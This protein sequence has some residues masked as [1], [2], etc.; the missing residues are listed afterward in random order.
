MKPKAGI[1]FLQNSGE[2]SK[3]PEN[4][5]HFLLKTEGIDKEALG[6]YI[7]EPDELN[8]K[9]MYAFVDLHDFTSLRIDHAMRKLL[10]SFKLPGEAQK[11]DRIIE[12]FAEK[13]MS[14]NPVS[15]V[16]ANEAYLLSYAIMM[17]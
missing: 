10:F 3:E 5:A 6:N 8:L 9:V 4:V 11:I 2:L 17:L 15:Y 1:S 16:T 14:D 12:K 7:G 13:Y